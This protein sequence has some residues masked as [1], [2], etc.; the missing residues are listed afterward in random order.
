LLSPHPGQVKGEFNSDG[1]DPV[2]PA[3]GHK[4]SQRI[5]DALFTDRVEETE[6]AYDA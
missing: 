4:L 2:D 5:H 1:T 3:T 6:K